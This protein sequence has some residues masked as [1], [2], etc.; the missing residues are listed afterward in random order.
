MLFIIFNVKAVDVVVELRDAR[1]PASTAHPLV[2]EW[3]G[4]GQ[5]RIVVFA[6]RD[7]A[8]PQV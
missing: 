6:R 4:E 3:V 8:P 5:P 1:I 7:M 2:H